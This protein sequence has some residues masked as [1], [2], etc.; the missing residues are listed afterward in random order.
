MSLMVIDG[1]V[2]FACRLLCFFSLSGVGMEK[3]G[4]ADL[5]F[6]CLCIYCLRTRISLECSME[7]IESNCT[8]I[9]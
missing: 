1:G 8:L 4:L 7:S 3:S 2:S 9:T 6:N 5:L